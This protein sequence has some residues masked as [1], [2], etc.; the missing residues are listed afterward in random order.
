MKR[1]IVLI[2]IISLLV[3]FIF[4]NNKTYAALQSN[5]SAP[6]RN[7]LTGWMLS[8]RQMEGAGG[9][10]G[11]KETI[12]SS[13]LLS[14][15]GSNDLDIHMEK[16]TEYGA[17]AI[18]S[19][20]S[21]G[22]PNKIASGQTTTG[23]ETGIVM[24]INKE[25]VAAGYPTRVSA[26]QNANGKYK[27]VYSG[28]ISETG[29]SGSGIQ[30]VF[31][32]GLSYARK[33][34][35]AISET[36]GW[37]GSGSSQWIGVQIWDY[38]PQQRQYRINEGGILR[39]YSGSIFSYYGRSYTENRSIYLAENWNAALSDSHYSKSWPSRAIMVCGEG[40]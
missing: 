1:K 29:S 39:A 10:L 33:V 18:L 9:T 13:S 7:S 2:L 38:Y 26:F 35:D 31:M 28:S 19:A 14:T 36:N 24:N 11:L 20:S 22:N 32:Y 3:T 30:K 5:G 34:G 40:I 8:I 27:N 23:N 16:N 25:W 21:Y 15:S 12:N 4:I 17:I 6:A 37:H